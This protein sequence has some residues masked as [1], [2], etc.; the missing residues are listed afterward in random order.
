MNQ[1]MNQ[2]LKVAK[3]AAKES[4][5]IFLKYFG[6]ATNVRDKQGLNRNIVTEAD[7]AIEKVLRKHIRKA[8]P[9]HKIL[10][11]EFGGK[12]EIKKGE[13]LW[14]LDPIDGTNN[15]A[16]GIPICCISI[17]L[18]DFTGPVM[19]YVTSPVT[20]ETFEAVKG[21]GTKYNGKITKVSNISN[22]KKSFGA[23]GWSSYSTTKEI[24]EV[25]FLAS[26]K[27]GKVRALGS[28]V[29]EMCYVAVGKMDFYFAKGIKIWDIASGALLVSEAE[30]KITA[31]NGN[32]LKTTD[33]SMVSSNGKLHS[34]ILKNLH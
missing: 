16:Q 32:P 29:M 30:G 17:A 26:K 5:K 8:F 3:I 4:E 21:T 27:F 2:Y 34:Y 7:L 25:F 18:W 19:A 31:Y 23:Y 1:E 11:E 13:F 20:K 15:F 12:P 10:G 22:P 14:I 33:T 6:R 9:A 28:S 24:N